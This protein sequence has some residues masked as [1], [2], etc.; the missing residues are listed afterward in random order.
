MEKLKK[1][2]VLMTTLLLT[3]LLIQ[4]SSVNV[5]GCSRG[6]IDSI[7]PACQKDSY[8]EW[9]D[10]NGQAYLFIYAQNYY[11]L[12]L[13]TGQYLTAEILTFNSILEYLIYSNGLSMDQILYFANIYNQFIPEVYQLEMQ[14]IADATGLTYTQILFQII[15]L[16][17]YYGILQPLMIGIDSLHACTAIGISNG[18]YRQNTL[19]Q[20][21]D[22]GLAFY[23]TLSWVKYKVA[24][25]NM[26]FSLRM[27]AMSLTIGKNK[28]VTST[29]TLV[30][31][32]KVGDFG[33]PTTI[34][35]RIAFETCNTALE[36]SDIMTSSCCCGWNYIITDRKGTMIATESL[37]GIVINEQIKGRIFAVKTNTY[38]NEALKP[39]LVDPYYSLERQTKAEELTQYKLNEDRRVSIFGLMEIL[40]YYDGTDSSITRMPDLNDPLSV[41]T[42]AFFSVNTRCSKRGFFGIGNP[43]LDE[44]GRIP[45]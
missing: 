26:V 20:T 14:G 44:W 19:G 9:R 16:D 12:G 43:L 41:C 38:T 39:F 31:T 27:G 10:S 7:K 15:F 6:S 5:V 36:F 13:L 28:K 34:K 22:F 42:E 17:L 8:A 23:P 30:Q 3:T 32:W 21:M 29:M 1:V 4:M 40:S 33:V 2:M 24:D 37:S 11:D 25:K 45:I 35:T 18:R